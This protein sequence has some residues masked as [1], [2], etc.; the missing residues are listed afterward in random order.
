MWRHECSRDHARLLWFVTAHFKIA[1]IFSYLFLILFQLTSDWP[2][3]Y[4]QSCFTQHAISEFLFK[5]P[6]LVF[7]YILQSDGPQQNS[8]L[9]QGIWLKIMIIHIVTHLISRYDDN[10]KNCLL[11]TSPSPRDGLLSR[12]PSSA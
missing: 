7:L 12:M 1:S 11:Y 4:V 8:D 10:I 9:M 2:S 5:L 6:F 3:K